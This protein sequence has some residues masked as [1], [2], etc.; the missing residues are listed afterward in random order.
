[1]IDKMRVM[2]QIKIDDKNDEADGENDVNGESDE[3][4]EKDDENDETDG[5]NDVNGG[6]HK[7]VTVLGT[8][9]GK[10]LLPSKDN[11][12][13]LIFAVS[14]T[15]SNSSQNLCRCDKFL[16]FCEKIYLLPV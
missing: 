12:N 1:M 13:N 6:L 15:V 8:M 16:W 3:T 11:A 4:D 5:E 9:F 7:R 14:L 2:K 10:V